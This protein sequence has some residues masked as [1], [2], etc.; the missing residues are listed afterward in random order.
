MYTHRHKRPPVK[1]LVNNIK[2]A[3]NVIEDEFHI[4]VCDAYTQLRH[5]YKN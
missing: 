2:Y 1:G 5:K 3:A 4:F